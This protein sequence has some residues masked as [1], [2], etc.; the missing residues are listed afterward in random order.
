MIAE[1]AIETAEIA[2]HASHGNLGLHAHTNDV[3]SAHTLIDMGTNRF[4]SPRQAVL[5]QRLLRYR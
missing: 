2:I 3:A 4:S 5:A 1:S